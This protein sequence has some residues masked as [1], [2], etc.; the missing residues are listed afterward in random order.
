MERRSRMTGEIS[1]R[2]E[3]KHAA[4]LK[5]LGY[6]RHPQ[7]AGW[8]RPVRR[9]WFPRFHLYTEVDWNA[10]LIRLDLHLDYAREDAD[11]WAP[12]SSR[13]GA[14]VSA[15]LQRI[16]NAF[17]EQSSGALSRSR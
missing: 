11:A 5:R 13:D 12:T 2:H 14:V 1:L 9:A 4:A 7:G 6:R 15:E 16:L 17:P 10:K 8:V 3:K